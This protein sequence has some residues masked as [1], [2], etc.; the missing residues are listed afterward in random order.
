NGAVTIGA[1]VTSGTVSGGAASANFALPASTNAG[2]YTIQ[3]VY[4]PGPNFTTS[5]D[6]THTLTVG[7]ATPV[8][9]WSNPA[10][11]TSAGAL[12]PSQLNATASVPGT[13]VYTPAL[14]AVLP[15]G[16]GQTL[17][18]QFMPTDTTDYNNASKSV[19]I[20]VLPAPSPA[21]LIMTQTLA[22]DGNT[23]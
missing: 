17:S 14:G 10:D 15:V 5:S 8:I 19:Q 9:T 11:T 16:N 22:R 13:F 12:S 2:S 6:S 3:A 18:V 20:N 7:K 21:S 23:N 4:N 1:P